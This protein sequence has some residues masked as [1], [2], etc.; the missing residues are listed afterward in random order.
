MPRNTSNRRGLL[1]GTALLV[2]RLAAPDTANDATRD[3]Q[4]GDG[5]LEMMRTIQQSGW[6]GPIGLVVQRHEDAEVVLRNDFL[7]LDWLAAELKQPGSGRGNQ[8]LTYSPISHPSE[9][10]QSII[11]SSRIQN[12]IGTRA[13]RHALRITLDS[14]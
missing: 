2:S 14:G 6:K 7:G 13:V 1:Q 9:W 5:E 10:H 11:R 8:S 4:Q 12:S 3:G